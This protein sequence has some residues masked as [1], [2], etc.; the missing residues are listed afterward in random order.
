MNDGYVEWLKC[1]GYR[2][3]LTISTQEEICDRAYVFAKVNSY[4]VVEVVSFAS[5][6]DVV[7][8]TFANTPVTIDWF[9][10]ATVAKFKQWPL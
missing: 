2:R 6:T 8:Y 4:G 9:E 10:S 5:D 7:E 3:V 1:N